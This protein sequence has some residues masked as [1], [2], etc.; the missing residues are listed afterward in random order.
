MD[1]P[2]KIN[3]AYSSLIWE[4]GACCVARGDITGMTR[5]RAANNL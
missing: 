4:E 5:H 1:I 2:D 3:A